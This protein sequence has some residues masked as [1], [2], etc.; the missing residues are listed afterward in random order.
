MSSWPLKDDAQHP[1]TRSFLTFPC[2]IN[3][4]SSTVC[5]PPTVW[6]SP[7]NSHLRKMIAYFSPVTSIA[8]CCADSAER[9]RGGETSCFIVLEFIY[10]TPVACRLRFVIS[11]ARCFVV[12]GV[13]AFWDLPTGRCNSGPDQLLPKGFQSCM[14]PRLMREE[15]NI[16]LI[17][18]CWWWNRRNCFYSWWQNHMTLKSFY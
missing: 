15:Q 4:A 2:A 6:R 14:N 3:A 17:I 12:I 9:E 10:R 5:H 13:S 16:L 1:K 8:T 18:L 11:R 7:P